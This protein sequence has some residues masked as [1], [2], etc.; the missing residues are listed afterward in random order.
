MMRLSFVRKKIQKELLD[1]HLN[2]RGQTTVLEETA[3][4]C[5]GYQDLSLVNTFR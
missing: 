4:K 5:F 3:D 2:H 1:V